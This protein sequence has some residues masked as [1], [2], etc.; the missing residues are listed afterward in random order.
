MS[1]GCFLTCNTGLVVEELEPLLREEAEPDGGPVDGPGPAGEVDQI[2]LGVL[3][4]G[5][6]G[7][8]RVVGSQGQGSGSN[9]K[10]HWNEIMI[11]LTEITQDFNNART[12]SLDGHNDGDMVSRALFEVFWYFLTRF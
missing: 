1:W 6:R 4:G 10:P 8:G 12:E 9:G 7:G 5:S 3:G 11:Q 2:A